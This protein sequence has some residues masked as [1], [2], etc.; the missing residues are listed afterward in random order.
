M[1]IGSAGPGNG[2]TMRLG[3]G[4]LRVT[5]RKETRRASALD[6]SR[7]FRA[8]V[9]MSIGG[10]VVVVV[11]VVVVDVVVVDGGSVL[12]VVGVMVV[13]G[14]DVVVVAVGGVVVDVDVVGVG[15]EGGTVVVVVVVTPGLLAG[16]AGSVCASSSVRSK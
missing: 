13:V 14:V 3:V 11:V 6:P 4:S 7:R 2:G 12:V 10:S 15:V 16:S 1:T 9:P 8:V 5:E